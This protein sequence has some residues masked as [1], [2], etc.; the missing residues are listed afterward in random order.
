M[1]APGGDLDLA[2]KP[3]VITG[4]SAQFAG[5]AFQSAAARQSGNGRCL[6]VDS[7]GLAR[8]APR[9]EDVPSLQKE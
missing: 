4:Y 9:S 6:V 5:D 1:D 2:Q 7:V 8:K 3:S